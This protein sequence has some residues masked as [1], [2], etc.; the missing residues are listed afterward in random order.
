MV[1]D[2]GLLRVAGPAVRQ[3]AAAGD[4]AMD[5]LLGDPHRLGLRFLRRAGGSVQV[6]VRDRVQRLAELRAVAIQGVG[7]E[8]Q[9]PAQ[10]V[11]LLDVLDGRVVRHVDRLGDRPRDERL[12]RRHHADVRLGGQ[13]SLALLAA[14]VG[15]VED[16]VDAPA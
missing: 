5:D 10:Q 15:A 8:H 9:L 13:E 12:G 1:A 7:L 3:A 14:L 2:A 4:V 16:R 6:G 11:G